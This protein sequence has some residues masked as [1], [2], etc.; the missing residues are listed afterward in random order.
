MFDRHVDALQSCN[1]VI[2]DL[3]ARFDINGIIC[4]LPESNRAAK[5][6]AKKLG[7]AFCGFSKLDDR[8]FGCYKKEV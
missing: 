7:M 6:L 4:Y 5:M 2:K 1:D 3:K 8:V